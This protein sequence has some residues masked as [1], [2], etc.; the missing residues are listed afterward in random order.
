MIGDVAPHADQLEAMR[1]AYERER[2]A[3]REA[4]QIGERATAELYE[5]IQQLRAVQADVV[6]H[7]DRERVANAL[8]RELRL[9]LDSRRLLER[10]VRTI[11]DATL[12]DR[13]QVH[14]LDAPDPRLQLV[15]WARPGLDHAPP[16][17]L[18][19]LALG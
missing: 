13:C 10:A 3:R 1:R 18:D 14:L 15:E 5:T 16:I 17:S 6:D 19:D 8:A 2:R 7:A 9:E 4:E 12:V 11:G